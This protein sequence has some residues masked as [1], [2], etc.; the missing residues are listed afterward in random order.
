MFDKFYKHSSSKRKE[1]LHEIDR[2]DYTLDIALEEAVYEN[3]IENSIGTYEIPMGVVPGFF[4]NGRVYIIPM[5]TEEPSV[6]AAQSNAAKIFAKNGGISAHVIS[7]LMRGQIAFPDTGHAQKIIDYVEDNQ[8]QLINYCNEAYPSIVNRGG[9]VRSITVRY[10]QSNKFS[11][12]VIV[13][14]LMDTQEAMGANMINTTLEALKSHIENTLGVESIMAILSNLSDECIVEASVTLDVSTLKNSESIAEKMELASDLAHVDIYRAT[15]HNKGIMNGIDALVI[16]TGNDFRAV[17]AGVHAYASL[18]GN[19]QPLTTWK[20]LNETTLLGTIKL[21]ISIGTVG[22]TINVH[23]KAKQAYKI[24]GINDSKT[25]MQII[26]GVGLA[27]NFAALYAL[28]TDGIQKGHMR[29]HA[30]TLLMNA[31][32]PSDSI[33]KALEELI[34]EKPM[35]LEKATMIANK[36]K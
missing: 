2:L 14:V 1:I 6:I 27:Q 4:M 30:R 16:A 26:A 9:G 12:F 31:G 32:C 28:T 20:K 22:G 35:N 13:D 23:P 11:S 24:L 18:S 3:M 17:E 21:P 5:V 8:D 15:T 29:M 7:R 33:E 36:Y 19:Y 34:K 10:I 25:L